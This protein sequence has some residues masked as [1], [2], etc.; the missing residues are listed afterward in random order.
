MGFY[1]NGFCYFSSGLILLSLNDYR[2]FKVKAVAG[3]LVVIYSKPP[4]Y[5]FCLISYE[6][7]K[8]IEL[9]KGKEI[10][11]KNKKLL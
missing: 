2:V 1:L 9:K 7:E 11:L 5:H 4:H 6:K 10:E 3:E 8:Q